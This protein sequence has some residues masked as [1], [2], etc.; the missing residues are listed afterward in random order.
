MREN[1]ALSAWQRDE[2]TIGCWLSLANSHSAEVM[3]HTGFDWV[4]VDLQHGLVDYADMVTMLTA[5]STT[6]ATPLVRVPWNEPYEIMKALDAGAYG[7]IVPLVNNRA[8]AEQAVAA[9]RYPPEGI[10]SF[11]PARASLYAGPGYLTEANAHMAC[12]VMIE[13]KEAL[14]NLDEIL[15]T[16][17]VDAAYIGPADLAFALELTPT[18][19][20]DHPVHVAAV[21][22][23]YEACQKHQVAAGI[24][25]GSLQY[26][27]RY[28]DQGFQ[29]V[30]LGQDSAFMARLAR[31]ELKAAR[32]PE[33]GQS[34]KE[35]G[36]FY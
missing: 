20:N 25:T 36:K 26:T 31:K 24:H 5:I 7:V 35:P 22:R 29:M 15:S 34:P 13:T 1:K 3:A 28:L 16:P 32:N 11:G 18:G 9:C 19:D 12:I 27:Q 33:A 8:E 21:T 4:C 6:E 2:Q 23:I 30:T 17:G 10:R 14:D